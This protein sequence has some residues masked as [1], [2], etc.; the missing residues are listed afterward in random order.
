[1]TRIMLDAETAKKF[2]DLAKPV[3]LCDPDGRLLG[4]FTPTA[5][6]AE[7]RPTTPDLSDEELERRARSTEWY[8]TAQVFE[9][10]KRLEE[11]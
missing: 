5:Q 10:L 4:Q 1:M 2:K 9:H 7:W 6:G 8:T 3:Q 11:K